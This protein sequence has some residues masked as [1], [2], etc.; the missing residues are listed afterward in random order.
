MNIAFLG[1]G[2][3]G[4]PM[5][6]RMAAT[7]HELRI[8][9]RSADKARALEGPGVTVSPDPVAAIAGAD[10][11]CICLMDGRAIEDL[12]YGSQQLADALRSDQVVVNFST[13]GVD[14]DRRFARDIA[15][16][17]LDCPVSGGV[18][19]AEA[20]SLAIFVGGER[21]A[22]EKA[23]PVL[24]AVAARVTH[25]GAVGAGQ[26]TKLC[27]Q[28][29]A[30]TNLA[31]IAEAVALGDALGVDTARLPEALG[32]GFADSRP[33]QLFGARMAAPVD[34]GPAVGTIATMRKDVELCRD[35]AR[36]QHIALPLLDA[37]ARAY[38]IVA[39]Y[40]LADAGLPALMAP[41]RKK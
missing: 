6:R 30:S 22:F 11:V 29:I 24:D 37:V 36:S 27:N 5:A 31:A 32:G 28:L 8:W 12:L 7:G 25:M 23:G 20:G 18:A 26:A 13:S 21:D 41:Y 15:A 4:A 17:W 40:G 3:M 34:P 1:T 19:G 38:R 2:L 16:R 39:E 9:N 33:L 35:A 14:A 10:I